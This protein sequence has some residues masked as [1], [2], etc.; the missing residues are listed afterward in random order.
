MEKQTEIIDWKDVYKFPLE[1]KFGCKVMTPD[2]NMAF[3]FIPSW[4][5]D[6]PTLQI[7]SE[8]KQKI[9]RVLNGSDEKILNKYEIT[10]KN[11]TISVNGLAMI[12]VRG[13][14]HLT[15]RNGLNLAEYKAIKIQNDF[16]NFIV[17][18]LKKAQ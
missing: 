17:E 12:W 9:V 8:D 7:S 10:H 5:S 13:W 18:T 4:I 3:D 16:A 11:G 14:G 2:F 1:F 6:I 15:G